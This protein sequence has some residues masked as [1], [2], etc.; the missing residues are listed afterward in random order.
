MQPDNPNSCI[1]VWAVG[2]SL[3]LL[4]SF[5]LVSDLANPGQALLEGETMFWGYLLGYSLLNGSDEISIC[6]EPETHY[7]LLHRTD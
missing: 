4:L 2:I 7:C 1:K 5:L 3:V 6:H